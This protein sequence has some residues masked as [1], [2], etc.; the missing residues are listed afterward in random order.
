MSGVA[1]VSGP[2]NAPYAAGSAPAANQRVW[3]V[4]EDFTYQ[5]SMITGSD[6]SYAFAVPGADRYLVYTDIQEPFQVNVPAR[7]SSR[8]RIIS[9]RCP[10]M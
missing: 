7:T 2:Q 1:Y 4:N 5:H 8:S 6:G 3:I 10:L 9:S